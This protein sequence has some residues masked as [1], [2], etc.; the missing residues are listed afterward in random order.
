MF[1]LQTFADPGEDGRRFDIDIYESPEAFS[2]IGPAEDDTVWTLDTLLSWNEAVDPDPYDTPLYQVWLS[3]LEDMSNAVM[4]A[5]SLDSLSMPTDNLEDD[6]AYYW[7]VYASDSN[8]PGTWATDTL[9]FATYFPEA[10][11]EF[12]LSE[13]TDGEIVGT[14][15]VIARWRAAI[16]PD[17]NDQITYMVE[18]SLDAA[19]ATVN[20]E[21]TVDTFLMITEIEE[22]LHMQRKSNSLKRNRNSGLKAKGLFAEGKIR[23]DSRNTKSSKK[24][25]A[26]GGKGTNELD[27]LPEGVNIYWRVRAI[28]RFNL[29]VWGNGEDTG[30]SFRINAPDAPE[31]FSLVSPENASTLDIDAV[32]FNWNSTTDSDSDEVVETY[33]VTWATDVAFTENVDSAEVNGT[34]HDIDELEDGVVYWWKVRA[35]DNNTDG[36]WSDEIWVFQVN[37]PDAPEPFELVYPADGNTVDTSTVTLT[38]AAAFDNDYDDQITYI[39]EWSSS[40]GFAENRT[41]SE[42]LEDTF[43]TITELDLQYDDRSIFW[44]VK[45]IDSYDL[46]SWSNAGESGNSFDV[47]IA[48]A[49]EAFQR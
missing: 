31:A 15:T 49:P 37:I 27:E 1:A 41:Q 40:S 9:S 14:D 45:A 42:T 13:P 19:F 33:V 28:D 7:T 34:S 18:W 38:W 4:V 48:Q 22:L 17:P 21:T 12:A 35:L 30:W 11:L 5:D 26:I 43:F 44:R 2:L 23:S 3:M 25:R 10:P 6:Q 39:L 16:D 46:E 36:T 24:S 29:S 20:S 8:T 32:T 47:R